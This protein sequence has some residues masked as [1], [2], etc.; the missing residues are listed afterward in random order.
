MQKLVSPS[1]F[2]GDV[3]NEKLE[4]IAQDLFEV[5]QKD[6]KE[7]SPLICF[8]FVDF[9]NIVFSM[10]PKS[11]P[12]ME[13]MCNFIVK[14]IFSSPFQNNKLFSQYIEF[15]T[16]V[17][18]APKRKLNIKVDIHQV[19]K[20]IFN[21]SHSIPTDLMKKFFFF[22]MI[23]S[24]YL[25][26]EDGK[27]VRDELFPYFGNSAKASCTLT[28][29]FVL[30]LPP[31]AVEEYFN[32]ALN[33]PYQYFYRI[34][35]L[36]LLMKR[37]I[38]D[39]ENNFDYNA[40]IPT[41]FDSIYMLLSRPQNKK[42]SRNAEIVGI[43]SIFVT[44]L[45]PNMMVHLA[46]FPNFKKYFP[47]FLANMQTGI[48]HQTILELLGS[49]MFYI[50]EL[51]NAVKKYNIPHRFNQDTLHYLIV[52]LS[53]FTQTFM[54]GL[55]M[56][57]STIPLGVFQKFFVNDPDVFI[58][59]FIPFA[60]DNLSSFSD[61]ISTIT[62]LRIAVPYTRYCLSKENFDSKFDD[63]IT[64]Y[65]AAI[66]AI[67]DS[68]PAH[69]ELGGL[70]LL[71][72]FIKI[73]ITKPRP[74]Y[75]ANVN[76][77]LQTIIESF[78]ILFGVVL[79]EPVNSTVKYIDTICNIAIRNSSDDVAEIALKAYLN[80]L[81]NGSNLI[82]TNNFFL[83]LRHPMIS[84][85]AEELMKSKY[86]KMANT[87]IILGSI[88]IA[89]RDVRL[90]LFEYFKTCDTSKEEVYVGVN[91]AITV[92]LSF[93]PGY[94]DSPSPFQSLKDN[95]DFQEAPH[96][97]WFPTIQ[98]NDIVLKYDIFTPEWRNQIFKDVLDYLRS[99]RDSII[100]YRNVG[101]LGSYSPIKRSEFL[102]GPIDKN[103]LAEIDKEEI[104]AAEN[105]ATQRD[106]KS[107]IVQAE[108]RIFNM[109]LQITPQ[110]LPTGYNYSRRNR[111]TTSAYSDAFKFVASTCNILFSDRSVSAALTKRLIALDMRDYQSVG[112]GS[113]SGLGLLVLAMES[114]EDVVAGFE[115]II[116]KLESGFES[117][118]DAQASLMC[119]LRAGTRMMIN[120]D[121]SYLHRVLKAII[122]I[123]RTP[124]PASWNVNRLLRDLVVT[125]SGGGSFEP[126]DDN[127]FQ[128]L[129]ETTEKLP[130]MIQ[131][132]NEELSI[133]IITFAISF[134][135]GRIGPK[136]LS[137]ILDG[138][139]KKDTILSPNIISLFSRIASEGQHGRMFEKHPKS[140]ADEYRLMQPFYGRY[141]MPEHISTVGTFNSSL[142]TEIIE[143]VR[144]LSIPN[145]IGILCDKIKTVNT[146]H[147]RFVRSAFLI[148]LMAFP[149]QSPIIVEY[150]GKYI[151]DNCPELAIMLL[152]C[153]NQLTNLSREEFSGLI[154][155]TMKPALNIMFE[156]A[157]VSDYQSFVS[158][159]PTVLAHTSSNEFMWVLDVLKTQIENATTPVRLEWIIHQV[160]LSAFAI[161]FRQSKRFYEF[162]EKV[163]RPVIVF[164]SIPIAVANS[165]AELIASLMSLD[166]DGSIVTGLCH[167]FLTDAMKYPSDFFVVMPTLL[168]ICNEVAAKS[169]APFLLDNLEYIFS[170]HE[171]P[172]A[173]MT[174]VND[175]RKMSI[176]FIAM[177]SVDSALILIKKLCAF[178]PRMQTNAK[179]SF[180]NGLS[181]FLKQH[182]FRLEQTFK[183][184]LVN[185]VVKILADESM[186]SVQKE[187]RV[188]IMRM[189]T[190]FLDDSE[191]ILAGIYE[192]DKASILKG[193]SLVMSTMLSF[194]CPEWLLNII[195][196]LY[197]TYDKNCSLA[198][199]VENAFRIFYYNHRYH[200]IEAIE[201]YRSL[202]PLSYCA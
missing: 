71:E 49:Y 69:T 124:Y 37:T 93:V 147:G 98:R 145:L 70:I 17:T 118:L 3:T 45:I 134:I 8:H 197:D 58:Q 200:N 66:Q 89:N 161:G 115:P 168:S 129:Y 34:P 2:P 122:G 16:T 60:M 6:E 62:A 24:T 172:P 186:P 176:R 151:D 95:S 184:Y 154:D 157:K 126:S 88:A 79:N 198:L 136:L 133:T 97:F 32:I 4:G 29:Y 143:R 36:F 1:F 50:E 158:V 139:I 113:L 28:I 175:L 86:S 152:F 153:L 91:T 18:V 21:D 125:I 14:Q 149:E 127:S 135:E 72:F 116:A 67:Q 40:L 170:Q 119:G 112:H 189:S 130:E 202:S 165:V 46:T 56:H 121:P 194:E 150:V 73:Y 96:K 107:F 20:Y 114:R 159:I 26:E 19:I 11:V 109:A 144:K 195:R 35:T 106:I 167:G 94:C 104:W 42:S 75:P 22:L 84:Q 148:F 54:F 108:K 44:Q 103:L 48:K 171:L 101:K 31:N 180:I 51:D 41:I 76:F 90:K 74:E 193:C 142:L 15:F 43:F 105:V 52:E 33:Q 77:L 87:S 128:I 92:L 131:D 9:K 59:D 160:N 38:C 177:G 82:N 68:K 169:M 64:L 166:P 23:I 132:I 181:M 191:N 63:I 138:I 100:Y 7:K 192:S 190:F 78:Q 188:L 164:P 199:V 81:K 182:F 5:I 137:F 123:A 39:V 179:L 173:K 140:Q 102:I 110:L 201:M 80:S 30:L 111:N 117:A 61:S 85:I 25:T 183:D 10:R 47:G 146:R 174:D 196:A 12:L 178:Y 141:F 162:F 185:D 55:A 65:N 120:L 156:K 99:I 13:K 187:G 53:K 57:N 27:V 83:G 163:I 155:S